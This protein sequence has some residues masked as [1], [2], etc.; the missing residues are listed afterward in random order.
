MLI[1]D[2][3][4]PP[5]LD[6]SGYLNLFNQIKQTWVDPELEKRKQAGKIKDGFTVEKILIKMPRDKPAIIQFNNECGWIAHV[7]KDHDSSFQKNDPVYIHQITKIIDVM[8][9]KIDDS[10][11]AFIFLHMVKGMWRISFD[12]LPS[13]EDWNEFEKHWPLGKIIADSLQQDIEEKIIMITPAANNLLA[14]VGFVGISSLNSIPLKQN[15]QA[16]I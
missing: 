2:I 3:K 14:E 10:P 12:F 16:V 6:E 7:Q 8:R 15:Y 5:I 13:H 1:K 4:I 11:V 9:P